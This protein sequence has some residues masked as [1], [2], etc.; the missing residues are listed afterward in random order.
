M[1]DTH[2]EMATPPERLSAAAAEE[3]ALALRTKIQRHD[4]LYHAVGRPEISDAAYD[5]L[6]RRL[7]ALEEAL[8]ELVTKD[9]PTRRVGAA[10]K[11]DLP[12]VV[13]TAPMLSLDSTQDADEVRRFDERVRSAVDVDAVEYLLEPKLDGVSI[14]LVYEDG[15]LTRAVTRGNGREGEGVTDNVRTISSVPLRLWTEERPSPEILAVRGEV[16]MPLSAFETLNQSL[17]EEGAEPYANPR[18]ATSGAIRQLDSSITARRPLDC[19]AYELLYARGVSFRTDQAVLE[20]LE[21]WGFRVPDRIQ[22][23]RTANEILD[24]HAAYQMDR[25]SLDYEID[26]VVVKL[27]DLDERVDLGSTSHHPR[28]AI[29][30]KFEPRKEATRVDRIAIQ[31]GR[32]GALTPV[33]LLLPVEV[34]GVTVSRATLHN[35]EELGRKDIRE[36]DLVRVQRA[37]DVIPQVVEVV[38]EEGRSRGPPFEMPDRCPNCGTP[39]QVSGPFTLCPNRFGCSAQLKGRIVHFA[40]RNGLDIEGL[41]FETAALLVERGLVGELADLFELTSDQLQAL[42]GFAQKSAEK[43]VQATRARRSTEFRRFLFGLGIPEVGVSVAGDLAVHFRGFEA[44]READADALQA[45][46]GIGP[47][48]AEQISSF[49][50][51]PRIIDALRSVLEKMES[52]TVPE[53]TEGSG[54]LEGRR[55]AFT[56]TLESMARA[57]AQ[58]LVEAAG[59][60]TTSTVSKET[61]FLVRGQGGGSKVEKA[62]Q[63]DVTILS[64]E[65]FLE[66]LEELGIEGF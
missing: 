22:C 21:S 41:G 50:H 17:I 37:G 36:G 1:T 59:A 14:E 58:Q 61:D 10:P 28:W 15:V 11:S 29:A 66:R 43:L 9:S 62:R 19:L 23:V 65:A 38:P 48:M 63:L 8:P 31:V 49:L 26:G 52:L 60:Q 30:F 6:F 33:A 3:E 47:K 57:R 64:E 44:L 56:G 4:H 5:A 55:F 18:N 7:K 20:A 39:V 27:N 46:R 16:L 40:S 25:D 32:T 12:T 53:L 24:Y 35:R 13:H 51:D 45:V 34:G 54:P 42:P 2:S